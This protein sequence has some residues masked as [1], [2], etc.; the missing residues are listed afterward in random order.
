SVSGF[1][2]ADHPC[3]ASR[4]VTNQ[5]PGSLL[6]IGN[7]KYTSSVSSL[8]PFDLRAIFRRYH[9]NAARRRSRPKKLVPGDWPRGGESTN[10][11]FPDNRRRRPSEIS[12]VGGDWSI[13][14]TLRSK[15][16]LRRSL[17]PAKPE[18]D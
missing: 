9:S 3:V 16:W 15:S 6:E 2:R 17:F 8:S 1:G 10:L 7:K 11:G 18:S 4:E 13:N 14:A 5:R 12:E